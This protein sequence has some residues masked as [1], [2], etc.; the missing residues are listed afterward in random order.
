MTDKIFIWDLDGTLLDS[1]AVIVGSVLEAY[2]DVGIKL[3]KAEVDDFVIKS[4]VGD[5]IKMME[6]TSGRDFSEMRSRYSA[7]SDRD[8]AKVLLE[9]N[10]REVLEALGE[11]GAKNYVY[12]H[13]GQTTE[14]VLKNLG[15][16][17][18]FEDI[19]SAMSGFARKP[20]PDALNYLIEKHGMDREKVFYVGDRV[21]DMECAKNAGVKG[22]LYLP[23]GSYCIPDGNETHTVGDLLDIVR[24]AD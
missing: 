3:D 20:A 12:T 18:C 19:V 14:F 6:K 4:S 23:D 11:K 10:A 8:K 17:D 5:F 21:I 7:I 13:R 24:Y 2:A 22:I 15:I 9:K 16:Y 1:Y